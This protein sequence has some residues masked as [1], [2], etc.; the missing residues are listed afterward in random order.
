MSEPVGHLSYLP[1]GSH[2][3]QKIG[4]SVQAWPFLRIKPS[5]AKR[6]KVRVPQHHL[7]PERNNLP[8]PPILLLPL[9]L[10]HAAHENV[11]HVQ[12]KPILLK[13]SLTRGQKKKILSICEIL[14]STSS[15]QT[16]S[17]NKF[18]EIFL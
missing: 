17:S 9:I 18:S 12:V 3:K 4:D 8:V 15:F 10:H 7:P 13:Q 5:K 2:H 6:A 11:P 16:L 14:R 1:R